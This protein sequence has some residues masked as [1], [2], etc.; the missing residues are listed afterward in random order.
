MLLWLSGDRG[1]YEES[2][3]RQYRQREQARP[4]VRGIPMVGVCNPLQLPCQATLTRIVSKVTFDLSATLPDGES[5]TL[6]SVKVKKVPNTVF[7]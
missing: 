3:D 1:R 4:G 2:V 6:K 7:F 5:F